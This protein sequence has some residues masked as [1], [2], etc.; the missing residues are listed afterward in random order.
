MVQ[1]CVFYLIIIHIY[2]IFS[3]KPDFLWKQT[4]KKQTNK[5]TKS[6]IL[7]IKSLLP[8]LGEDKETSWTTVSRL[9][10]LHASRMLFHPCT[11]CYRSSF[12]WHLTASLISTRGDNELRWRHRATASEEMRVLGAPGKAEGSPAA[13]GQHKHLSRSHDT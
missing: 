10:C 4:N 7:C 12:D 8:D 3:S 9:E 1:H 2:I 6:P 11:A 13:P 5:Q